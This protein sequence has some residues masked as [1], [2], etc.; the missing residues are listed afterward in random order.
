MDNE[1]TGKI[2]TISKMKQRGVFD[3]YIEYSLCIYGEHIFHPFL[4]VL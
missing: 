2:E 3:K 1:I 4:F